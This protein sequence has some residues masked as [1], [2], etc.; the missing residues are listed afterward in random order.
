MYH[1]DCKEQMNGDAKKVIPSKPPKQDTF[2]LI[3]V[4]HYKF[5]PD[6]AEEGVQDQQQVGQ[7]QV[8]QQVDH[9]QP[10]VWDL[11]DFDHHPEVDDGG[12]KD[13]QLV[14]RLV[15]DLW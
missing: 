9:S 6:A 7:G 8:N 2:T 5:G 13:E 10:F 1:N 12:Q 14:Q 4:D 11:Q 3:T 15:H